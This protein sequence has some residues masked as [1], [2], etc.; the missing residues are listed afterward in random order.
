MD[1]DAAR[2]IT[3]AREALA[4]SQ[5][6]SSDPMSLAEHVGAL[7]WHLAEMIALADQLTAKVA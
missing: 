4:A 6:A 5:T 2:N 1:A 7:K 3:R